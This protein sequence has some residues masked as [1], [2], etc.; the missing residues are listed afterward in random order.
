[1][2]T[3]RMRPTFTVTANGEAQ[4][5]LNRVVGEFKARTDEFVVQSSRQHVIIAIGESK[6]H[7]WS[8]W[9]N[10]EFRDV[11][12]RCEVFGRFAPHPTIWT[13]IIFSYLALSVLILFSVV[14]GLSQW[15]ARESA[16]AFYLVPVWMVIGVGVWSTGQAG[17][18]LAHDEMVAMKN[19]LDRVIQSR[20]VETAVP[21]GTAT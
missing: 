16:W 7:F 20:D 10:L 5:S 4:S 15:M 11:D 12:Q 3:A 14:F 19:V 6:R 13:A 1:M 17:Q 2:T 8:P 21:N 18:K 9:L